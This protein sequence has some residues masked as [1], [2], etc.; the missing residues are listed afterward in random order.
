MC[1]IGVDIDGGN[2][3]VGWEFIG[4][5][6]GFCG[7]FN[8]D[9]LVLFVLIFVDDCGGGCF[10]VVC[11]VVVY[12]C[13]DGGCWWFVVECVVVVVVCVDCCVY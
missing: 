13:V 5:W 8:F 7:W 6:I 1:L 3:K 11:D 4:G 12:V 2:M 10:C 9:G